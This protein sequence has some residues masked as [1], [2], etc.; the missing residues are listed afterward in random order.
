[1]FSDLGVTLQKATLKLFSGDIQFLNLVFNT[2]VGQIIVSHK[3]VDGKERSPVTA[4]L[5]Q[6]SR[7]L[8]P[9]RTS[10]RPEAPCLESSVRCQ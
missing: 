6:F 10:E 3:Y 9:A 7:L 5:T 2:V 4:K 1:V 8:L